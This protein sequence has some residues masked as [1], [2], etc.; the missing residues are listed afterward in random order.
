MGC[1]VEQDGDRW[2]IDTSHPAYPHKRHDQAWEPIA[3]G[4]LV[5]RVL[6]S[7]GITSE[8]VEKWTR[9]AGKPGGCG[10]GGRR[11][12]LNETG[13]KV[14]WR[15]RSGYFAVQRFYLGE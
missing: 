14:Q 8:R 11:E 10:C 4:D 1:V 2:L 3:V 5:E 13:F 9:T 12:W 6:A 15:I 7:A